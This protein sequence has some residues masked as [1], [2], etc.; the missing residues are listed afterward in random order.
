[1]N[2]IIIHAVFPLNGE[3]GCSYTRASCTHMLVYTCTCRPTRLGV[4]SLSAR[5]SSKDMR[6][7]LIPGIPRGELLAGGWRSFTMLGIVLERFFRMDGLS[8]RVGPL[9]M[10]PEEGGRGGR[11]EG[12]KGQGEGGGGANDYFVVVQSMH[13]KQVVIQTTISFVL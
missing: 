9:G 3:R 13:G 12:G 5:K 6:S 10:S 4:L 7:S 8:L 1:M 11:E 2:Q